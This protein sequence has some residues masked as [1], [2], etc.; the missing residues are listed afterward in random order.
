MLRPVSRRCSGA[1][2]TARGASHP[3]PRPPGPLVAGDCATFVMTSADAKAPIDAFA[4]LAET[5]LRWRAWA[6]HSSY[7]G[8]HRDA[9]MRSLLA[10][11]ALT[12][13][14]TGGIVAAP[15]T[16]LPQCLGGV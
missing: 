14:A 3:R 15:T 16:S 9:V 7:A 8:P 10:L 5:G 13:R 1:P 4:A 2:S 12:H 6:A 11:K